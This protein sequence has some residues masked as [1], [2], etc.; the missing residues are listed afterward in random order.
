MQQILLYVAFS[1][2]SINLFFGVRIDFI[3]V[4]FILL[5]ALFLADSSAFTEFEILVSAFCLSVFHC[6]QYCCSSLSAACRIVTSFAYADCLTNYRTFSLALVFGGDFVYQ[7]YISV[8]ALRYFCPLSGQC[9]VVGLNCRE[10]HEQSSTNPL[11]AFFH[12]KIKIVCFLF[13]TFPSMVIGISFSRRKA[14]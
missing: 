5:S 7:T 11:T 4:L 14:A 13:S 12:A 2:N 9:V 1:Q 10:V 6:H 8:G 3:N